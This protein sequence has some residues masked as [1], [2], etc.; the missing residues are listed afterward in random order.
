MAN[1]GRSD[2]LHVSWRPAGGVIDNYV[3]RLQDHGQVVHTIAVSHSSPP[4]CSFSSLVAGRLYSIVIVARSGGLEN[5]TAVKA[6][7]RELSLWHFFTLFHL[8]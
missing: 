1:G 6:R 8:I 3:V 5:N 2:A 7:T 4:E